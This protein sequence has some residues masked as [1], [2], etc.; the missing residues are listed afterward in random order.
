VVSVG[1]GSAIESSFTEPSS[2]AIV[3]VMSALGSLEANYCDR[4]LGKF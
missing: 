4:C 2:G 1:G 3:I